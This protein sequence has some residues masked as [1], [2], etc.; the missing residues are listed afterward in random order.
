MVG[1]LT[2]A[3]A[4]LLLLALVLVQGSLGYARVG[5]V[6]GALCMSACA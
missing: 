4:G 1:R 2:S 6:M 5:L 3:L